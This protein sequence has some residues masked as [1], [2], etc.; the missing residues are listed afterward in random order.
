MERPAARV[1]EPPFFLRLPTTTVE[2]RFFLIGLLGLGIAASL[3]DRNW[4]LV[5]IAGLLAV[6]IASV[7]F[8]G[9]NLGRLSVVRRLPDRAMAGE[10]F[11]VNL[12]VTNGRRLFP[13][14]GIIVKDALQT[15]RAGAPS[16][17]FAPVIPPGSRAGFT[18][19][20]RI[21]RRGEYVI[22]VTLLSTRFPFGL[23][24]KNRI[25]RGESR[26]VVHPR[27]FEVDERDV[28]E[29]RT[30]RRGADSRSPRRGGQ[31]TLAG[32]RDY[33]TGDDPRRIAWRATAHHGRPMLKLFEEDRPRRLVLLF[34]AC[35][36]GGGSFERAVS[37]SASLVEHFAG[38][39]RA[40]LFCA[41]GFSREVSEGTGSGAVLDHLATVE[42]C[43]AGELPALVTE[44][45]V[46]RL[47]GA[48]VLAVVPGRVPG[49]VPV[50][51]VKVRV[52][53]PRPASRS[54]APA[55]SPE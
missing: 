7:L 28:A 43:T 34:A 16:I 50:H 13:A 8:A 48:E 35:G 32:L 37:L 41:P 40:F 29:A 4:A 18:Y 21:R 1:R 22:G 42:P 9:L 23:L 25:A 45:G 3:S 53:S 6:V 49:E 27:T 5:V 31:D 55:R 19:Q 12:A 52:L 46:E 54:T 2:G 30:A 26:I 39:R 15:G 20:A 11:G 47:R 51:G 10:A 38:R 14:R 36:V 33:R 24:V 17:C 44:V